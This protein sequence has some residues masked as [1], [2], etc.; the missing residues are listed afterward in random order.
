MLVFLCRF[1]SGCCEDMLFVSQRAN[2]LVH[3]GVYVKRLRCAIR[4]YRSTKHSL[5]H[6]NGKAVP[7][8]FWNW[9]LKL[10]SGR[11]LNLKLVWGFLVLKGTFYISSVENTWLIAGFFLYKR[12]AKNSYFRWQKQVWFLLCQILRWDCNFP[13]SKR[14]CP[15]AVWINVSPRSVV[16]HRPCCCCLFCWGE[17]LESI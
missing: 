12:E 3:G 16:R 6:W 13:R 17:G 14:S 11:L 4:G 10:K 7:G 1:V 15:S 5:N 8:A 9:N 2:G